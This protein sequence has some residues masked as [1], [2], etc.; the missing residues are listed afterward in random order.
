MSPVIELVSRREAGGSAPHD[1][2][3]FAA[4]QRGQPR[5]HPSVGKGRLYDIQFVVMHGHRFSVHAVD[6]GLFTQ[7]RTYAARK[8]REIAGL[9]EP[10]ESVPLVACIDL[11][12]PFRD[13]IVQGAA[14]HHSLEPDGALAHGHTAVH[15]ARPL[16]PSLL[17]PQGIMKLSIVREPLQRRAVNIFLSLVFQKSCCFSHDRFLYFPGNCC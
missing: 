1:G 8:L 6:A 9:E 3:L 15:A 4:A 13:Q 16:L 2:D 7:C 17:R 10:G 12:I 5:L 11:V 14:C